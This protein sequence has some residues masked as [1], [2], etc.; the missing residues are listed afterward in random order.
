MEFCNIGS[1]IKTIVLCPVD[2]VCSALKSGKART[3]HFCTS[4]MIAI[5][6]CGLFALGSISQNSISDKKFRKKIS[7][8]KFSDNFLKILLKK[9]S[10]THPT[11][12]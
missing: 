2:C 10:Q 7:D 11:N 4:H 5:I 6:L 8:E 3:S 1:S 12:T 9:F